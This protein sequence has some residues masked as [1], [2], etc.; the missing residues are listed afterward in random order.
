M[1]MDTSLIAPIKSK[2]DEKLGKYCVKIKLRRD[3]TSQKLELYEFKIALFDNSN[4]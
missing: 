2:S 1:Y 4:P 3:L